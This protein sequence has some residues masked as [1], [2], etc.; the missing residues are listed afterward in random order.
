MPDDYSPTPHTDPTFADSREDFLGRL[1]PAVPPR[2]RAI[3]STAAGAGLR[4]RAARRSTRAGSWGECPGLT[5]SSDED[6]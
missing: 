5:W 4:G 6:L 3:V 2:H 1:L